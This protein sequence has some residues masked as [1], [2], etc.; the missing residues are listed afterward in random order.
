MGGWPSSCPRSGSF[1]LP[2]DGRGAGGGVKL[3]FGRTHTAANA[4][5]GINDAHTAAKAAGRFHFDLLFCECAARVTERLARLRT[6]ERCGHLTRRSI[7]ALRGLQNAG[8][9]R[10]LPRCGQT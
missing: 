7:E 3:A 10:M 2:R 9:R 5:I 6:G 1:W 4:A 8:R